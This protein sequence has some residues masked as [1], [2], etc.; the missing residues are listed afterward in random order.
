[1]AKEITAKTILNKTKQRDPW[2]LDD[3]TVNPYSACSYNCLY[4]YIRGSKY[5]EHMQRAVSVKINAAELLDKQLTLRA[6]KEQYGFIVFSSVTDPYLHLES[7]YRLTRQLLEVVLRHRF[8]VHIITKS[9]MVVRDFDLIH[10][11]DK[12]A[13]L[14]K[15][16]NCTNPRGA[17]VTFSFS[18]LD[19]TIARIFEPGAVSPN[20]RLKALSASVDSGLHSGVSLMPL[21]PYI[22]DTGESLEN[23]YSTFTEYGAQYI[24][25]ASLSLYG[26]GRSDSKT[27]VLKAVEKHYPHLLNKYQKFFTYSSQMPAYYRKAFDLKMNELHE[28][29]AISRQIFPAR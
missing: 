22:S 4:C 9:D 24:L 13:I 5:G 1:M 17:L 12:R 8:P 23:F 27:L 18:T 20:S 2:L 16:L 3:Y 11:I 10:E 28:K 21:L 26:S 6:R 14:P 25:P 29:Y 19:D 7:E 15:D